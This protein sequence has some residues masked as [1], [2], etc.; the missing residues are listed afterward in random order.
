MNENLI[1]KYREFIG[2]NDFFDSLIGN[3][4]VSKHKKTKKEKEHRRVSKEEADTDISPFVDEAY[5]F[6]TT[7]AY[8]SGTLREYQLEGVNWLINMNY[9]S[10]NCILADEMGLGKTLQTITFLGYLKFFKKISN[11]HL[12]IVPKS[13]L[14]NW[15]S[16]FTKFLPEFRILVFHTSKKELK[17]NTSSLNEMDYDVCITTYEMCLLAKNSLKNISWNYIVIDEAHR[18][19]NEKSMLSQIVRIF[20]CEHRLLLTGTPLQNNIH[21][22]WALLNFLVPELFNDSDHFEESVMRIDQENEDSV[23]KLRNVLQVFFLR[24]EKREVEQTLL[25][26][27]IVNLYPRLTQMQR[28]WYKMILERDLSPILGKR[29]SK[30]M[31]MNIVCQLRKCCNHPYLFDGAEPGPPFTTDEHLVENC[32]KMVILDKLLKNLKTKESRILIFSQ[33]S[34]MLDILEDYCIFREFDYCRIDGSTS[35]DDRTAAIDEFN[36]DGSK[37]F[38]FLLTT[39][40]GGLGIN[41][42]TADIVIIYDSDWNPQMDLQAQDRAHRIGQKKQVF[43]YRFITEKTIEER[44]IQRSL[45]KLKL[46]EVLVQQSSK[47]TAT[48]NQKELLEIIASGVE[49]IYENDQDTKTGEVI[50]FNDK[51]IEDIIKEGEEKTKELS[52]KLEGINFL[53]SKMANTDLYEWEG[54]DYSVK[55]KLENYIGSKIPRKGARTVSLLKKVKPRIYNL[56]EYQ[57]FPKKIYDLQEKEI[58]SYDQDEPGLTDEELTLKEQL[59]SEGF[60]DWTKKDYYNFIKAMEISGKDNLEGITQH[61]FF[62]DPETVKRYYKVFWERIKELSDYEKIL[63]QLNKAEEKSNRNKQI[64]NILDFKFSKGIHHIKLQYAANTRSKFY[65]ENIDKF[66]LYSYYR[67][68]NDSNVFEKILWEIRRTDM[69]N[70]DYYIK[71]RI[72]G[73]LMRRINV[74]TTNLLKYE[75]LDDIKSEYREK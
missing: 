46:D 61:F 66:L 38:V 10:I 67:N 22:L 49:N 70:M 40:A 73:D 54:E 18:I 12:L 17:V 26:K 53:E 11:P 60:P 1:K 6:R 5:T 71:T 28:D 72:A 32:G 27:K 57:F 56:P 42:A 52:S 36:S 19:K 58:K 25:P 62:K 63:Q 4:T 3:R 68:F 47:T 29:D 65:T 37:K 44:I 75:S 9:N 41:L 20:N 48:I 45:Q 30:S 39:R 7:P 43:V 13:I 33:M 2:E 23:E 59:Y 34:R 69:F 74:L 14:H 55:N 35:T 31:L 8:I 51:N 50:Q 24:R 21:E 64:K 16:E 15:K